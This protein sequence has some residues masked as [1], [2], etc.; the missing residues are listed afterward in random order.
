MIRHDI[1]AHGDHHGHV[2][3]RTDGMKAK[4]GGPAICDE[5]A[6]EAL[7]V[8]LQGKEAAGTT[9]RA[10]F[11]VVKERIRQVMVERWSASHDDEHS[12]RELAK[13]AASYAYEAGRTDHQR[14]LD[15]GTLPLSWPWANKWWKPTTRRRDLVKAA[16][17]ILAEIER[18]D[19][20]AERQA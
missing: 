10:A 3:P 20:Q 12:N 16:A 7:L 4:C 6:A 15:E 13:A 19:R 14:K 9:F 11:D 2:I 17:L 8:G 5:C 1:E 18:L